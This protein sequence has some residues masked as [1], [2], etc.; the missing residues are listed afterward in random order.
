MLLGNACCDTYESSQLLLPH[1]P[2]LTCNHARSIGVLSCT[3]LEWQNIGL[4][5]L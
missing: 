2:D 4:M 1:A 5:S 3:S